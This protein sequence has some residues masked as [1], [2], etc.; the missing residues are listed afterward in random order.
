ML[1]AW[2][3][4]ENWMILYSDTSVIH[5]V[6]LEYIPYTNATSCMCILTCMCVSVADIVG[7]LGFRLK[8]LWVKFKY[9][10]RAVRSR[11]SNRTVTSRYSI[12]VAFSEKERKTRLVT[13]KRGLQK[14][15]TFVLFLLFFKL[16][17]FCFKLLAEVNLHSSAEQKPP[18][19]NLDP[20]LYMY[21]PFCYYCVLI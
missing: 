6:L 4:L 9:S 21:Q 12:A 15:M 18:F 14:L 8:P 5:V 10:N 7:F 13:E 16:F 19:E 2:N 17:F 20:P 3:M 1:T 11:P